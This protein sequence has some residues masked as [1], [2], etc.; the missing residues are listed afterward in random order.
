ML[1]KFIQCL[2]FGVFMSHWRKKKSGGSMGQLEIGSGES[3]AARVEDTGQEA[4]GIRSK[5]I[6]KVCHQE[7]WFY[8]RQKNHHF[9]HPG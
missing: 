8:M 9:L 4:E 2:K 3:A 5:K 7:F 6:F 1:L